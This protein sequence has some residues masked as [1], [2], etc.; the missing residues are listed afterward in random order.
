MDLCHCAEPAPEKLN[1]GLVCINCRRWYDEA[2][3]K[4]DSRVKRAQIEARRFTK[5]QQDIVDSI[6]RDGQNG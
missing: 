5:E 3:W 4:Q 1:G 2:A 6:M